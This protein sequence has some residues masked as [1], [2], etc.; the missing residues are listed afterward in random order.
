LVR[1]LRHS[2]PRRSIRPAPSICTLTLTLLIL[3]IKIQAKYTSETSVTLSIHI[4]KKAKSRMNTN[5]FRAYLSWFSAFFGGLCY[6]SLVILHIFH[7]KE[8]IPNFI[9]FYQAASI[10]LRVAVVCP[11]SWKCLQ[12]K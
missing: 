8:R 4:M 6:L 12:R 7:R 5:Y 3:N 10:R 9:H 1:A 11:T 2:W